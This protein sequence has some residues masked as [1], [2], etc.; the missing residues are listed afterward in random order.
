MLVV[1]RP[2]AA[3]ILTIWEHCLPL[4]PLGRAVSML[5]MTNPDMSKETVAAMPIGLRDMNLLRLRELT[6]GGRL[7]GIATCPKC[8]GKVELSIEANELL[9]SASPDQS[10]GSGE[11][12]IVRNGYQVRFRLP[13]SAD[14]ASLADA[15]PSDQ[16]DRTLLG[17]CLTWAAKDNS[18]V[19]VSD[20]PDEVVDAIAESMDQH[21]PM[22]SIDCACVCSV[23]GHNWLAPLDLPAF[24]WT[25]LDDYA[26]RL[27][28]D[29]HVLASGYGWPEADILALT[30]TR[31]Q[32]YLELVAG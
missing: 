1:I 31:R 9:A 26:K 2:S 28:N 13:T 10:G 6:F 18:P 24:V 27:L 17:R 3:D 32:V 11:V 22:A 25:E 19:A 23:C 21:D 29:V 14:L 4:P 8:D 7:T 12:E 20:L 30:P 16:L 5:E 15:P